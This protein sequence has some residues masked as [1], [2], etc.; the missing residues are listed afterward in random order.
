ML[1]IPLIPDRKFIYKFKNYFFGT[2]FLISFSKHI[3]DVI[4]LF[5]KM[6]LNYLIIKILF[7]VNN[8]EDNQLFWKLDKI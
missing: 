5:D 6:Y 1:G 8:L 4:L 7:W 3:I 2:G